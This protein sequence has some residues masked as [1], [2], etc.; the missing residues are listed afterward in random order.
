MRTAGPLAALAALVV[1]ILAGEAH[2][3]DA[4]VPSLVAAAALLLLALAVP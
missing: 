2:G 1:G 3:P 4:A